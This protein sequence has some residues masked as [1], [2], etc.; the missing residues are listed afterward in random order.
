[1]AQTAVNIEFSQVWSL[2]A[3]AEILTCWYALIL[4]HENMG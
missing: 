3:A 1:M 2:Q 4:T